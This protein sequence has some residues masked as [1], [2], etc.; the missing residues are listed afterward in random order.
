MGGWA[1]VCRRDV[2]GSG[3]VEQ[4]DSEFLGLCHSFVRE[5]KGSARVVAM[6]IWSAS[7]L[8]LWDDTFP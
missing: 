4:N 7:S 3:T 1:I 6:S 2:V 5:L 8:E